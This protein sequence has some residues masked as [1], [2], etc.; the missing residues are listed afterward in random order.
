M[1]L[2]DAMSLPAPPRPE[3]ITSFIAFLLIAV[4]AVAVHLLTG[5]RPRIAFIALVALG[6]I[7]LYFSYAVDY[8]ATST[9]YGPAVKGSTW[10]VAVIAAACLAACWHGRHLLVRSPGVGLRQPHSTDR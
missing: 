9:T 8:Y 7:G 5:P 3:S 6:V 2:L 10:P 4:L 1:S